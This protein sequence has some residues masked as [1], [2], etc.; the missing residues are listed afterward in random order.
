MTGKQKALAAVCIAAAVVIGMAA[1]LWMTS[2]APR[3]AY[4]FDAFGNVAHGLTAQP[5]GLLKAYSLTRDKYIPV[6][7]PVWNGERERFVQFR[8]AF[9]T[10]YYF[11]HEVKY[12]PLG[13]T[14]MWLHVKL[15]GLFDPSLAA[16]TFLERL[17]FSSL[18]IVCDALMAVAAWLIAKELF[19]VKAGWI[20]ATVTWFYP[21]LMMNTSF[22]GQMDSWAQAPMMFALLFMLHAALAVGRDFRRNR[23]A[24]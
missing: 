17:V 12:P 13:L 1:R 21:P 10:D 7:G 3:Y 6:T 2:L 11:P 16:N 23:D 4:V 5:E 9:G 24:V 15:L 14:G 22:W 8:E 20:A 18:A 19:G